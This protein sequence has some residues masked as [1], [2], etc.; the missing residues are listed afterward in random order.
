MYMMDPWHIKNIESKLKNIVL[1]GWC[2]LRMMGIFCI[3]D[4]IKLKM[5]IV[6]LESNAENGS[7]NM[8]ICNVFVFAVSSMAMEQ[9]FRSP[10]DTCFT[11]V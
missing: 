7:S 1:V 11:R 6:D 10:P 3:L 8:N 5:S 9:R 4:C 2:T